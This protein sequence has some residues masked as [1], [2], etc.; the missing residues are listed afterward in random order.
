MS[1]FRNA[2]I[3]I[4][5]YSPAK[6]AQFAKVLLCRLGSWE[7]VGTRKDAVATLQHKR[8]VDNLDQMQNI[9][10]DILLKTQQNE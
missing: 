10:S 6:G 5:C 2:E 1:D 7:D 8:P 3:R 9:K 4:V